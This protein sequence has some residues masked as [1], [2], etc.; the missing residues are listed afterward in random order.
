MPDTE[1]RCA[2]CNR[3]HGVDGYNPMHPFRSKT[4]PAFMV[5]DPEQLKPKAVVGPFD[6]VLRQALIDKGVITIDDLRDAEAKILV[7]TGQFHESVREI[8]REVNDDD[9]T[10]RPTSGV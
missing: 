4:Q 1:N 10:A 3:E 8:I 6:P 2:T 7:V 5:E 9:G